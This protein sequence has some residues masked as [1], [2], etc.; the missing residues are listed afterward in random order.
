MSLLFV[1]VAAAGALLILYAWGLPPFTTT[2]QSTDDAYVRG[3]TTIISPQV[4]GYVTQVLV[5]DFQQVKAGQPLAKIDD[6]TY[7]QRVEQAQANVA[8]Q[9]AA[10]ANSQQSE[11]S[12]RASAVAQA[13]AIANAQAQLARA[14]ADMRRV[15]ELVGQG[16]VSL[17]ERDQTLAAL[18]QAQAGVQQA[19]AQHIIATEQIRTVTVGRG[20][21][22]AAVENAQAALRLAQIDLSNTIVRA[23][24]DGQLSEVS[25]RVGQYVTAGTQL[26]F[27]V[28]PAVWVGANYK[29]AQTAHMV[30]GQPASL[31]VD[32]LGGAAIRGFV[33]RMAPAAGTEFSVIRPDN[34]TGNFVKVAQRIAVRIA[35]DPRDPMVARLRPGMSVEARIDTSAQPVRR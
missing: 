18:R 16:S 3:Q 2:V 27:L 29:E 17:R 14:Q 21:L 24:Q 22:Q 7:R 32:A 1:L 26:L 28:P 15:N 6:R 31:R 23:P 30:P 11:R 8:T 4:S 35:L 12:S 9:L 25:V 33:E 10:L 5:Q 34:A 13:A 20:G 19:R